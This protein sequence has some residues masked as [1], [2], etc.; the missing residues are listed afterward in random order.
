MNLLC[1]A[2]F[3][4]KRIMVERG[5]SGPLSRKFVRQRCFQWVVNARRTPPQRRLPV[6]QDFQPPLCLTPTKERMMVRSRTRPV[7]IDQADLPW[8]GWE[9]TDVA[10]RSAI[11]WKLLIAGE[12][13]ESAGLVTGIAEVPPG[14]RLLLHHHGPEETYLHR[15]RARAHGNR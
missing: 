9:D 2:W 14:D 4:A 1:F 15:E 12:R 7:I 3:L 8:E 5:D 10:A 13:T 6:Q 11:R